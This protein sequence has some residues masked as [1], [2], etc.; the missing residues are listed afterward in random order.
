[1]TR[2][3]IVAAVLLVGSLPRTA[4][5]QHPDRFGVYAVVPLYEESDLHR[6]GGVSWRKQ[7]GRGLGPP[8]RVRRLDTGR[9]LGPR[10]LGVGRQEL[11]AAGR[12]G[13]VPARW[14]RSHRLPHIRRGRGRSVGSAR[15]STGDRQDPSARGNEACHAESSLSPPSRSCYLWSRAPRSR[16]RSTVGRYR[17]RSRSGR[18]RSQ[19]HQH[20]TNRNPHGREAGLYSLARSRGHSPVA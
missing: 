19:R 13:A 7:I 1:M 17:P 5:G 16:S 11:R 9:S 4:A 15:G 14:R 2:T 6:G 8:R 12:L 20:R 3:A 10:G 18:C